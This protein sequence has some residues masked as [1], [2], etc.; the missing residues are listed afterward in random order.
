MHVKGTGRTVTVITLSGLMLMTVKQW[1]KVML[2]K[3]PELN[4]RLKV[5]M[6]NGG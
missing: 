3:I 6:M 4:C 2:R 1:L 5:S